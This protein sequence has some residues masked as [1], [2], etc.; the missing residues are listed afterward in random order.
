MLFT[1]CMHRLTQSAGA[2]REMMEEE[3]RCSSDPIRLAAFKQHMRSQWAQS[4]LGRFDFAKLAQ[5]A[6]PLK[7]IRAQQHPEVRLQWR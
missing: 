3:E 1:A 4:S 7:V 2:F 5:N 6:D